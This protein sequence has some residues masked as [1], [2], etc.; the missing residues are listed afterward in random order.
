MEVVKRTAPRITFWFLD[1]GCYAHLCGKNDGFSVLDLEFRELVRW[2]ED[3]HMQVMG[4]G[5]VRIDI[6]GIV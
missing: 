5:N 3:S 2:G 1:S 6:N 4:K